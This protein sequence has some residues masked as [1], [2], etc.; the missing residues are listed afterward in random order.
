M[1]CKICYKFS[2]SRET[3]RATE[4]LERAQ[5]KLKK[6]GKA[7]KHFILSPPHWLHRLPLDKLR[8]EAYKIVE[9]V[10]SVRRMELVRGKPKPVKRKNRNVGG[11]MLLHAYRK[12]HDTKMWY[13]SPHFH[14]VGFGWIEDTKEEFNQSGWIVKNKGRRD[15]VSKTVY[16]LLSHCTIVRGK[17]KS[18]HA[19]TWYGSASYSKLKIEKKEDET[20]KCPH[21]HQDLVDLQPLE[22]YKPPDDM[23]PGLVSCGLYYHPTASDSRRSNK[24]N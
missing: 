15:S 10:T 18:K 12:N 22:P 11:M 7:L 1:T 14:A 8:K 5:K 2:L 3:A 17:R 6:D 16:Y 9:S 24:V 23:E 21:C 19:V 20:K 13:F 4:R